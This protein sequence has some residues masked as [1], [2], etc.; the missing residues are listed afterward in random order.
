V[1]THSAK[2]TIG[3]NKVTEVLVTGLPAKFDLKEGEVAWYSKGLCQALIIPE[4]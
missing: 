4:L 2:F 1:P 3:G